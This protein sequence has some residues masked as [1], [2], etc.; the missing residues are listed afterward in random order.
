MQQISKYS[1]LSV[2]RQEL[3]D[4]EIIQNLGLE[5]GKWMGGGPLKTKYPFNRNND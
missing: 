3:T 4:Q 5:K 2:C 1:F